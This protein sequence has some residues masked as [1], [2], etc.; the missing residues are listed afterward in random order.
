[1]DVTQIILDDHRDQRRLFAMIEQIDPQDTLSLAAL[2]RRL[3]A[4]LDAHAEAEERFFY[5]A[6]LRIG[7]GAND[8]P[9]AQ[10]E[11][12]DAIKDHN[13][14]RDA[15]A[16]VDRHDVG[17]EAWFAA[18]GAA[19]KANGDHMAEEERQGLTDFRRHATLEQ[20]HDLGVRLAVFVA[21]HLHGVRPVKKDPDTYVAS[22]GDVTEA[23][24]K[25]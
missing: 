15:A 25:S 21:D 4:L 2:W 17:S 8:A 22:G 16:E 24:E 19:N 3:S 11:T 1:L 23:A 9:S 18:L 20:R 6:L 5:P 10:E 7:R 12:E 13:E 14:I